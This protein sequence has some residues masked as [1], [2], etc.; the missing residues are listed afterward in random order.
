MEVLYSSTRNGEKKMTASQ[1]IL[2]GLSE[3]GGLFVPDHI[4][5]LPLTMRELAEQSYQETAY[6]VMKLFL[7]DF[8]EEELKNCIARA[9]DSK[10][11][12]EEIA[13]LVEAEGAYY[14]ELFHGATIAFKDMA[15]SILPHLM[16]TAAK[17]NHADREIVI[18]TATSGDTG[19]AAL[20]GF[21]DVKGTKIIVFYPKNGVS[22]IQEKQMVTQKG[23]NT[24]VV[25]I[26]GNFDDAQTGV[27]K[28]F[29]DPDF[30]EELAKQGVFLSSANSINWG[31]VLP[32]IVYYVSA[33]CDLM[34]EGALE[35]GDKLNVC[36]PTGNFGDILAAWYAKQMG[37]PLGKLICASN[38]NNVLTDFIRT[39]VYD[40]NRPFHNTISPS[41]DILISSNL[42]RLL[43]A[44]S[45]GD[46]AQV[47]G[48]MEQLSET[49]RYQV[50]KEIMWK[51]ERDF[52]AYFCDDAQT[53]KTIGKVWKEKNYLIDPH[54][55]V[56]V[57]ALAQ[58]RAETGDAAP[59]LVVS[60][61]S[62]FKF[63]PAVLEALGANAVTGLESIAALSR[64][65]GIDAP[66][67]LA[68][69]AGKQPRFDRCVE[70]DHMVDAV[71][72][73]LK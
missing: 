68:E 56:A 16:I 11:D 12:T 43:H 71:R 21:A 9:Y 73:M 37:V 58:Y 60:T 40:R 41:M 44:F 52:A 15:L 19:K 27:K 63:C 32:Q 17:K 62:P 65:T 2:Q 46:C 45:N 10:F 5:A 51:L 23:D 14:L 26:H 29:A 48:Y 50:A 6:E 42:E 69:L 25:G 30:R 4:P 54:T 35:K 47:K 33:Y 57:D 55:A 28:L 31:R 67:P 3:D 22:P 61:A 70:K 13:P 24:F 18:L 1:A 49:G 59:A 64:L 66:K 38:S 53:K 39:G 7:T 36:V 8:T 20:A 72:E 34:K